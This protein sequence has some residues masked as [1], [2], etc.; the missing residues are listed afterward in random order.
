MYD[1]EL[2]EEDGTGM[3]F[4]MGVH[5]GIGSRSAFFKGLDGAELRF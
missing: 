3:E 1:K 2:I 4:R 5:Y